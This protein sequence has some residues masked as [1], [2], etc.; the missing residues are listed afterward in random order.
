VINSTE[1][2]ALP[3]GNVGLQ[4]LAYVTPGFATTLADVGGT[5]D[6]WSAQGAYTLYHGK[7][8]TRASFDGFRNQYFI[9]AASGVG[10][11]T[12]SGT[13]EEMQLETSGM[14]ADAGSGS[15]NLNAIPRSGG[16]S[17]RTTLDGYFSNGAMQGDN[18]NDYL[19]SFNINSAAE[20]VNI[21]RIGGQFGGP[22][23][24][25]KVWFFAAVGRWVRA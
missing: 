10:Y 13:I 12:D 21:Y 14:G 2:D 6:S 20:V 8:G 25:D 15:T 24:R 7:T 5:R 23:M 17:F 16:N 22:V 19:R 18:L 4:T 3:A 1:L 9:G 11:I